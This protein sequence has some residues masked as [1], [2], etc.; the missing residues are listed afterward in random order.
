VC[1]AA[2][3]SGGKTAGAEHGAGDR[4]P[5]REAAPAGPAESVNA[6]QKQETE[7]LLSLSDLCN[8]QPDLLK[9]TVNFGR[10]STLLLQ[11]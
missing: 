10:A 1:R 11:T 7:T 4:S 2:E 9:K 8:F 5:K 3:G 6:E